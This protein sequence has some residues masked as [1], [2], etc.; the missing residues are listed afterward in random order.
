MRSFFDGVNENGRCFLNSFDKEISWELSIRKWMK[1]VGTCF[2]GEAKEWIDNNKEIN[3]ILQKKL[4]DE[5][6]KERFIQLICEKYPIARKHVLPK[7]DVI[8]KVFNMK[9]GNESIREYYERVNNSFIVE[10]DYRDRTEDVTLSEGELRWLAFVI[11]EWIRGVKSTKLLDYLADTPVDNL[12]H[13]YTIAEQWLQKKEERK[14]QQKEEHIRLQQ[15]LQE[16]VNH[17]RLQKPYESPPVLEQIRPEISEISTAT[18]DTSDTEFIDEIRASWSRKWPASTM[19]SEST[20]VNKSPSIS[21]PKPSQMQENCSVSSPR[22]PSPAQ[23][24]KPWLTQ[25]WR[26]RPLPET[27]PVDESPPAPKKNTYSLSESCIVDITNTPGKP[28]AS[29]STDWPVS[30]SLQKLSRKTSLVDKSPPVLEQTPC[31]LPE[32][33][34]IITDTSDT[35]SKTDEI[36]ASGPRKW[37]VAAAEKEVFD[38]TSTPAG[39]SKN[40]PAPHIEQNIEAVVALDNLPAESTVDVKTLNQEVFALAAVFDEFS[41]NPLASSHVKDIAIS[42]AVDAPSLEHLT[43]EDG[44]ATEAFDSG[45]TIGAPL[46][47]PLIQH[48]KNSETLEKDSA[49]IYELSALPTFDLSIDIDF[50]SY[51]IDTE[52]TEAVKPH[53][54]EQNPCETTYELPVLPIFD[55][56]IDIDF[57]TANT[58]TKS[59]GWS[60]SCTSSISRCISSVSTSTSVSDVASITSIVTSIDTDVTSIETMNKD[61]YE[62]EQSSSSCS[63]D[64]FV[65][66]SIECVVSENTDFYGGEQFCSPVDDIVDAIATVVVDTDALTLT[67]DMIEKKKPSACMSLLGLILLFVHLFV[68]CMAKKPKHKGLPKVKIKSLSEPEYINS[69]SKAV[70]G[71]FAESTYKIALFSGIQQRLKPLR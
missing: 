14:R 46:K 4:P 59:F 54:K 30:T 16:F 65:S 49:Y 13:A 68:E 47:N 66:A 22:T 51:T 10:L 1:I 31:N 7:Y 32:I 29:E 15:Q 9:Q 56:S 41:K 18:E 21:L 43:N 64:P 3:I 28:V 35:K 37:S 61:F 53:A 33:N 34:A 60:R 52:A 2:K 6:D 12:F 36:L 8:K 67:A 19:L 57:E 63:I 58:E 62:G 55:L 71:I 11:E 44:S 45:T 50:N 20:V 25:N 48:I 40:Q 5:A 23:T 24:S 27:C 17:A 26:A 42:A 69:R 38:S 70:A 39:A